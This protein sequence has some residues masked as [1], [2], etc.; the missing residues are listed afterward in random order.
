MKNIAVFF[1]GQS[2]E[3]EVSVITGMLT[4]NTVDSEKFNVIPIYVDDLGVWHSDKVLF[5]AD[6][7][8]LEKAKK[9]PQVTLILGSNALMGIKGKRLKRLGEIAVAINCMHGE[10]GEDGCL[11]GLLEM[12]GIPLCSP[13]IMASSVC[14][15]KYFTKTVLKGLGIKTLPCKQVKRVGDID[16]IEDKLKY[17]VIVKPNLL[18]SSIGVTVATDKKT[19]T[20]A[21][22]YALRFG[23]SAIIE[24]CLQNFIE[25]NCSAYM[26]E[27]G[28]V[29]VSECERP[30]GRTNLLTFSDKY[31]GGERQFPAKIDK[32]LADKIKAIT[33]KIYLELEARGIIRIDYFIHE[34]KVF[35][36]EINTTPGSLAYYL[37]TKT[38]KGFS[39][40]LSGLINLADSEHAKKSSF[41]RKF[42]SGILSGF[43]S[44]GAKQLKKS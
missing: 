40:I 10:R 35:V 31:I 43:G 25:I 24:P 9:L 36:N 39:E 28:E 13:S 26:A 27:N 33:K 8:N 6:K 2:V 29:V 30:I 32:A 1:G 41:E 22:D 21:V 15:N 14:M 37:H 11:S 4:A 38:L 7:F 44:K 16:L 5:D 3:H 42:R 12:C 18:G 34:G 19:L 17:P 23:E 20:G